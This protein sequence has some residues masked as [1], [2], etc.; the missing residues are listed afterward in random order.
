M[1]K[2]LLLVFITIQSILLAQYTT[3]NSGVQ[4]TMDDLV[5]NSGGTVTGAF[6]AYDVNGLIIVSANDEVV[7]NAGLTINFT[8]VNAG[9]EVNG[10]FKS[11]GTNLAEVTLTS[12]NPDSTGAYEGIRFNDSAI[13]SA[14]IIRYSRIEYAYY[15]LRAIDANPIL[16]NSILYKCRR[17]VQL[18]GSNAL[19][20]FNTIERSYEY[21]INMTLDSS[22]EILNNLIAYNNTQATSAKNQ[23]SVGLQGNN[24]PII[25]GNTIHS[26]QG[27][28]T[29]G[30][31]IWVSGAS[32]FSNA[33]IENNTIYNNSFGITLY[34]SSNGVVNVLVKEN[35]IY[36]NNVN[37]DALVSGSGINVNGSPFNKPIIVGNTINGN[38]WGITIQNGTTVQAG[39]E[40]NLGNLL[41]ADPNDDGFNHIYNN[42][43]PTGI[44]DLYN[45]CTND[46]YAQNNDWGVYDSLSIE[47]HIFHKVDNPAHGEVFFM[48]FWDGIVPVELVNF[49]AVQKNG[50]IELRWSTATETNNEGFKLE[51]SSFQNIWQEIAFIEGKGNST[52]RSE[53]LFE[54]KI[55][56]N[57]NYRYRLSQKDLDGT[58]NVLAVK[59]IEVNLLP[60]ALE[61]KQN[62]P[63]PFNPSTNIEFSLPK[64]GNIHLRVFNIQ[65]EEVATVLNGFY[66]AGSHRIEL[67]ND[68]LS[69]GVY[70]YTLNFENNI[71][72]RKFVIIK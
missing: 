1:K 12:A 33:V 23:I 13:D 32:N 66:T 58:I 49:D 7:I 25:Q 36:D 41:N 46:I 45:N 8:N 53:Y 9:F 19:I 37:P 42:V 16:E 70:F 59:E 20:H 52:V 35:N 71:I 4:W 44:F 6:P 69:S 14:C 63:N 64:E 40:P 30:I 5:L 2:I 3:P 67:R 56:G 51:R 10:K 18:S 68:H 28:R 55:S 31:S 65:G 24:S 39:P 11:L 57:G 17:G 43:Q 26:G 27:I 15:G 60:A 62:Y 54:D 61:L 29:G 47:D 50:I 21:G 38:W 34:S 72:T 48:P 22:P